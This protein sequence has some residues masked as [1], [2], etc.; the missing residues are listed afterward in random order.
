MHVEYRQ[1]VQQYEIFFWHFSLQSL[2][3]FLDIYHNIEL[4]SLK[5]IFFFSLLFQSGPPSR[6][7]VFWTP[8][9][10]W[11][12]GSPRPPGLR[13]PGQPP[14]SPRDTWG[15]TGSGRGSP[16]PARSK[17]VRLH[18][19]EIA[20]YAFYPSAISSRKTVEKIVYQCKK[21]LGTKKQIFVFNGKGVNEQFSFD[22]IY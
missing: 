18:N 2:F 4:A 6:S 15:R 21:K 1:T 12:P 19:E 5:N 9:P 17:E 10:G 11:R 16:W 13:P 7:S 22:I 3:F 14:P 20:K 8:P